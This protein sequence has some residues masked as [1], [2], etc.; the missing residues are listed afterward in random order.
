MLRRLSLAAVLLAGIAGAEQGENTVNAAGRSGKYERVLEGEARLDD[1]RHLHDRNTDTVYTMPVIQSLK[2]WEASRETIRRRTLLGAGLYPLPEKTPLNA[3]VSGRIERDGYTVERA[4]FE[5]WPGFLVTGNLYR[6]FP[7]PEEKIPAVLCPHG[8]WERGRLQNDESCSVPGRSITLARM[9]ATVFTYDMVGYNDSL[10]F[11]EHR[12]LNEASKLWGIT[13]F[14]L[15]L[16]SSIRAVDFLESLPEVDPARIGCTGASGGGT[17]TFALYAVDERIKVAAPVNMISCSMQGG[18]VCENGPLMRLTH[19]NLEIGAMMA[20]RPLLLV[21]ATGDW[22]RETPRIE[23][24]SIRSIYALYGAVD[25]LEQV[26]IDAGHNYNQASRE[27]MYRFFAKHLLG[28]EGYEDFTEPPFTVEPDEALR[29]FPDGKLPEGY[30]EGDALV[31][32]L[33]SYFA[34]QRA[35][36]LKPEHDA[37]ALLM[38]M[39]GCGDLSAEKPG[40]TRTSREDDGDQVIERWLVGSEARDEQVALV[41]IR[42]KDAAPQDIEIFVNTAPLNSWLTESGGLGPEPARALQAGRSV[43][44]VHLYG[45]GPEAPREARKRLHEA[46]VGF[47]D[48]FLPTAVGE[49]VRD[50]RMVHEWTTTRR[51]VKA[52]YAAHADGHHA[53]AVL[54]L[55]GV[56]DFL[57]R[58]PEAPGD[59]ALL[60]KSLYI[61]AFLTLFEPRV[62]GLQS[63]Q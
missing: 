48:T 53:A 28:K 41:Y 2:A 23:Y 61:P 44:L 63:A 30:L 56:P 1:R 10:Q 26:Q 58:A 34:A 5:A 49:H 50:L 36:R 22:T 33:K 6:P 9:G 38:E 14:A 37:Q 54:R 27:A 43:A 29:V 11:K 15:Q 39:T 59:P 13:P 31:A 25:N 62:L 19:S 17:Q 21:S 8:H 51:D 42:K 32:H 35:M 40:F 16:W 55:A 24:P 20:P 7:L 52:L 57:V 3:Q 12:W 60:E 47:G 18:C 46:G 4:Y 45:A